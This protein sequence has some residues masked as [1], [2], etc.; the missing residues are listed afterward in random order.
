MPVS[1]SRLRR[2]F[3]GGAIFVCI[4]VL[5]T[6]L[7]KKHRVQ[8]ALK[9]VPGKIGIQI[10]QSAQGFTISK[11]DQG[12]SLF[13]LQASKAIQFKQG[14]R[15]ELHDVTITLYGRDSSRFDQVYGQDFEY[16]QQSGNVTSRGEVSIDLQANPQGMLHP[17]QA[18]PKELKNP[19][20][21]KTTGLVFN[22]KTGDAWTKE[23][24]NFS[25][26][27]ANGSAVGAKYV[28]NEGVLN[29][30]S[31]V[32][33][34]VNGDTPST[35]SAERAVL[36]KV[37]RVIVLSH[38]RGES[39]SQRGQ[40][41]EVT[42]FLRDDNTLDRVLAE[43]NVQVDSSGDSSPTH[44]RAEK[45]KAHVGEENAIQNAVLSGHVQLRSDEPQSMDAQAGR[46]DLLFAGHNRLNRIHAAQQVRLLQHQLAKPVKDGRERPSPQ[47]YDS[48]DLEVTAQAMDF[49]V[50]GGKRLTRA[51]TIGPSQIL[52]AANEKEGETQVTADK[53]T[54]AFDSNGQLNQLQG[55]ANVRVV[56]KP[57][58]IGNVAQPD[59]VTA[60]DRITAQFR[61]GQG[62]V[63]LV[64]AG[65]FT[66]TS[67]TQRAFADQGSY[68]PADQMLELTGSPRIIDAGMET[69]ARSIR[70][71]RAT[72]IGNA[73]GDV[74]TSYSDLKPQPNGALLASSD[75]IHVSAQSMTSHNSPTTATY[76]GNA[77]LWQNANVIEA[78]SIQFQKEQRTVVGDSKG[79]QKVSTVLVGTD[80]SGKA[81]PVA[82]TSSHL[83]YRDPDRKAHFDGGVTVHGADMTI[84]SKQMDVF[85]RQA[86]GG[87]PVPQQS[88]NQGS[89]SN[90]GLAKLDKIIAS[91]SVLITQPNRRAT[92]DQL[93]YT[94][95]DDKFVLTGGPPSIFDAEHG[96]ITGVS[97]TLYR[98]NDRVVVEGDSSSPAVTQTRVVR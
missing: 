23:E 50:A 1:V 44:I 24:I 8:N 56:S 13:K 10:Q 48:Q 19:L 83:V 67:G 27:Q 22:Q 64:Q 53:F 80:K 51:D 75:P 32:R 39:R 81:T 4:V 60:S 66:Y 63:S 74:K 37:P 2:W 33:I 95:E 38:A 92:G 96:K 61:T 76:T 57:K 98:H 72:G 68:K 65:H 36:Q 49:F 52:L 43:G 86:T 29:L 47:N 34:A 71:N 85:L 46:A 78:P 40:A 14:G 9:Q 97:L 41:D 59:R 58:P 69:T 20:H 15:A 45:L 5:A 25:A 84:T 93:T 21:L 91:G 3:A 87:T 18:P 26:P 77:R 35:I 70:L 31:Q 94:S 90:A 62:I 11:S 79:D 28:A 55:G 6:F 12:R 89:Q 30:E 17:D 42:L 73:V 54:A 82:V 88:E 16:D 7:Y